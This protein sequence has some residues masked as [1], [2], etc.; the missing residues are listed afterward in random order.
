MEESYGTQN[1]M[2]GLFGGS[3]DNVGLHL[4]NIYAI[5]ELAR[6]ATAEEFPVV[7]ME[8]ARR[9][10]RKVTGCN[11]DDIISV[12]YRGNSV[13]G[14]NFRQWATGGLKD[15]LLRGDAIDQRMEQLEGKFD[16]GLARQE[17]DIA[18]L[19]G[20]GGFFVQ[21]PAP[22]LWRADGRW[23]VRGNGRRGRQSGQRGTRIM[24]GR[25]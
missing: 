14:V 2:A 11:L 9:V 6:E 19:K 24:D 17:A 21:S 4:K 3:V 1:Q 15:C 12:G 16:R 25:M 8:G 22:C 20:K 7:R 10:R 18:G 23:E 13:L 5:G